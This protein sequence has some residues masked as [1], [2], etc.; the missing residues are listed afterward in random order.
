ML[1]PLTLAENADGKSQVIRASGGHPFW[2]SG[3]GW[4]RARELTAGSRLHGLER[5]IDVKEVEF[6]EK[7]TKTFNLVVSEFHSYFVGPEA[8]LSHDN[9]LVQPIQSVVP[10]LTSN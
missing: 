1:R 2:V 9:S 7:P 3:K 6:E 10:G 8:V 5:F 4:V